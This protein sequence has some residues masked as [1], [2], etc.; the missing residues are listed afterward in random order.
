LETRDRHSFRLGRVHLENLASFRAPSFGSEC[1]ALELLALSSLVV[2]SSPLAVARI[3][4]QKTLSS[5]EIK[6][7]FLERPVDLDNHQIPGS[8]LLFPADAASICI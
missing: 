8:I 7:A 4:V 3:F 1:S 5:P 6:S 2:R